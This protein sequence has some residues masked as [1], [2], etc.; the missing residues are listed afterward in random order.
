MQLKANGV[1]ALANQMKLVEK[2]TNVLSKFIVRFQWH[3]INSIFSVCKQSFRIE[4]IQ[5]TQLRLSHS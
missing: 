1:H 2:K 4:E 5:E 3:E